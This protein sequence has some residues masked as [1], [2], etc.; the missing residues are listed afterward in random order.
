M[1]QWGLLGRLGHKALTPSPETEL[2]GHNGEE[3]P[4]R[5]YQLQDTN[6]Y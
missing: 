4:N 2:N 6:G 3:L 1:M 5:D